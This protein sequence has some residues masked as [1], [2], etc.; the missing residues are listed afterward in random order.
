MPAQVE[1]HLCTVDCQTARDAAAVTGEGLTGAKELRGQRG[2]RAVTEMMQSWCTTG[3]FTMG[4]PG[5][6]AN[7]CHPQL[8][9]PCAQ[10]AIANAIANA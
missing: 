10:D 5:S 3:M 8:Y 9:F 2:E 1:A 7:R 4:G 6:P